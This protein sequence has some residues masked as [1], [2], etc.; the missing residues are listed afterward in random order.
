MTTSFI[1]YRG[2]NGEARYVQRNVERIAAHLVA[3][4]DFQ[5]AS[6]DSAAIAHWRAQGDRLA[7]FL[8][9]NKGSE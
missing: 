8:T 7:A 3:C 1:I 5:D 9:L 6:K 4:R 2:I